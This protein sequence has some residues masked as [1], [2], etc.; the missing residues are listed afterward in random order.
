ME[1]PHARNR[2]LE[3]TVDLGQWVGQATQ[4]RPLH[5]PFLIDRGHQQS[6]MAVEGHAARPPVVV[7]LDVGERRRSGAGAGSWSRGSG[8]CA[9]PGPCPRAGRASKP[10]PP[11]PG[12]RTGRPPPPLE[13]TVL[14]RREATRERHCRRRWLGDPPEPRQTTPVRSVEASSAPRAP[15][16]VV[17]YAEASAMALFERP[18]AAAGR[19]QARCARGTHLLPRAGW[20]EGGSVTAAGGGPRGFNRRKVLNIQAAST[21]WARAAGL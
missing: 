9:T 5:H 10:R 6:G 16:R 8:W 21:H 2:T 15:R 3:V 11:W 19:P 20:P 1:R 14:A 17:A 12:A 18:I 4:E 13:M 7:G